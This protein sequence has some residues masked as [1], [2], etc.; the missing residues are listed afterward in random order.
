MP[1]DIK[2]T[3]DEPSGSRKEL[4]H[5]K[6]AQQAV[7]KHRQKKRPFEDRLL[8]SRKP[9]PRQWPNASKLQDA[10]G[11]QTIKLNNPERKKDSRQGT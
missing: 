4:M 10:F 2:K 3:R 8:N 5:R 11:R 1:A 9:S 7:H 6:D